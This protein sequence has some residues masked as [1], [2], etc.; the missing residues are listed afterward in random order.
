MTGSSLAAAFFILGHSGNRVLDESPSRVRTQ[1]LKQANGGSSTTTN[2]K[3]MTVR[4]A[5]RRITLPKRRI[6]NQDRDSMETKNTPPCP[7]FRQEKSEKNDRYAAR[8]AI[9]SASFEPESRVALGRAG[10]S[11]KPD[12]RNLNCDALAAGASLKKRKPRVGLSETTDREWDTLL[13]LGHARTSVHSENA[14]KDWKKLGPYDL[15]DPL[16]LA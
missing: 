12:G 6:T 16:E 2:R 4:G 5:V 9:P 15:C 1:A 13:L 7:N 8:L 11:G 10:N 3:T 14:W